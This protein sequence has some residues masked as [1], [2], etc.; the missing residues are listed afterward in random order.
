MTPLT[1]MVSTHYANPSHDS[2]FNLLAVNAVLRRG[3]Q[4]VSSCIESDFISIVAVDHTTIAQNTKPFDF[5]FNH[6]IL[7]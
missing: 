3:C 6:I 2:Y 1:I 7:L 4:G 5:Y